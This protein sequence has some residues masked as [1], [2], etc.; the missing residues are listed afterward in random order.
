MTWGRLLLPSASN[1]C[2][3]VLHTVSVVTRTTSVIFPQT[4]C[5]RCFVGC[6]CRRCGVHVYQWDLSN[7][8]VLWK[9]E[10]PDNV[11]LRFSSY[12]N[13]WVNLGL[14]LQDKLCPLYIAGDSVMQQWFHVY[15]S[16]KNKKNDK[17]ICLHNSMTHG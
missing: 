11:A 16:F 15:F 3:T 6:C 7:L 1:L 14:E 2:A 13:G 5:C 4:I 9:C 17:V 8:P 12:L 10:V